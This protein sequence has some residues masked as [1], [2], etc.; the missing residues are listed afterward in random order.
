MARTLDLNAFGCVLNRVSWEV[1]ARDQV[2]VA[3]MIFVLDD[4]LAV[5]RYG[6]VHE[7]AHEAAEIGGHEK[8]FKPGY[9]LGEKLPI[10]KAQQVEKVLHSPLDMLRC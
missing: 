9:G 3:V 5:L 6:D 8:G 4:G 10:D 1:S 7:L 2:R